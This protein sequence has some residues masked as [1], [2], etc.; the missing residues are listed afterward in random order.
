[1][2]GI[3]DVAKRAG[4]SISTVSNVLNKSKYVSPELVRRVED[5][6]KELSY[7]VNPIARSMKSNKSG[8]IGVITEDMCG[9]FYPYVV[10]GINSV[11]MEKGY[12][13]IICDTQGTYGDR[14]AVKREQELFRRLFANRVD[15]ILF[16][17]T[18]PNESQE[19]YFAHIKKL[20]NQYKKIPIVSLERDFTSVGIDSVY[21]DGLDN[22]KRA[23]Q[24]LI[25]CGCRKIGHITG[26]TVME[27]AQ[28]R[29]HGYRSCMEENHLPVDE[30]MIVNGDYTHQSGYMA[31]RK[32]LYDV[33]DLDGVFCGN[34]QM[35]VGAL[36]VLKEC[37][38]RVPEDIKLM[39]YDD[40]F[41]SSVVE[42]SIS[43]IHIQKKHAGIEAA[44]MLF[45]R[46][47]SADDDQQKPKGI[48]MDGRLVV[49]KS[50]VA[51][52]PEDWIL[53]DW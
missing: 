11:A 49:R 28:E 33:P 47:E 48:K 1:M 34:D 27:I 50:T 51:T 46:I 17:S 53:S 15:G 10:K 29:I 4:V 39:G 13:I 41:I 25:D 9:V 14:G 21:F 7:E 24:H 2:S 45:E 18:I 37:G 43:T 44:K 5:A 42:P 32:L 19:K 8:T 20:G 40:V 6:V 30:N 35:A 31:M 23:V 3:K 52:A 26:P 38:K 22:A 36:K 12:Q 16:V